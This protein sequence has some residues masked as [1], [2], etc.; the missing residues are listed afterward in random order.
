MEFSDLLLN[1]RI[2]D[3]IKNEGYT[4]PSPIQEQAI[5]PALKGRD[6]LGCA[7]TGTGKTAAFAT[8]ILHLLS[9]ED[10]Q[11]AQPPQQNGWARAKVQKPPVRALILS[12]TRELSMQIYESFRAYGKYLKLKCGLI[13]GGVSQYQQQRTL[14]Q[15][16][17]IL[18]ATPGRL[19]DLYNQK[20]LKLDRVEIFVLDEADRML[21]MGFIHDVKKVI[22]IIPKKRQTLF[23]TA[24]MPPE[25][26][27][28]AKSLL[29]NPVSVSVTPISSTVDTVT[30]TLYLTDKNSKID[31]LIDLL[32]NDE[33]IKSA[34]I[35][36]RTKYG[37][38]KLSMRLKKGGIDS[39]AIHGD[40]SQG[41]R[42]NALTGFKN[43]NI[44][45]L[46]ATDI[47]ARGIDIDDLSHVVNF[48]LPN[49]PETYVHRIGRTGRAGKS[50]VAISLCDFD[51]KEYVADIEKLIKKKLTVAENNP[52]PMTVFTKSPPKQKPPRRK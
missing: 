23:F 21:D 41:A 34:L 3:A 46:V 1:S 30:Q 51:E 35:F 50:G 49:I 33:S 48:E 39:M 18:V 6:I 12:P 22:E 10:E 19:L 5:P 42:Q 31:L 9:A 40:K 32:K 11:A 15:G 45:A 16:V 44:R 43:G 27:G 20:L 24:T 4:E 38:D 26:A 47:A 8:P 52:Y 29:Y 17:D 14:E 28:L 2:L 25:V 7:Q 36:T 37:A 13:M